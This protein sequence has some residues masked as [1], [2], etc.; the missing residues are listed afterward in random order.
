[1]TEQCT[2]RLASGNL[3][4]SVDYQHSADIVIGHG[5]RLAQ[6]EPIETGNGIGQRIAR[7]RSRIIVNA[8]SPSERTLELHAM[9]HFFYDSNLECFIGRTSSP[10]HE[11]DRSSTRIDRSAA[12]GIGL[13]SGREKAGG[14]WI[15][16][17]VGSTW[18][19]V[20]RGGQRWQNNIAVVGAEKLVHS[21]R[22]DIAQHHRQVS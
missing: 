4:T 7:N 14:A 12:D 18:P 13:C 2:L 9:A 10:V 5:A 11:P 8:L 22:P 3:P 1:M 15:S 16:G 19:Q 6:I 20:T 17:P 21:T